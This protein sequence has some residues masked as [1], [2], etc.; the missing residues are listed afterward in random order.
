MDFFLNSQFDDILPIWL[1]SIYAIVCVNR[2]LTLNSQIDILQDLQH[3]KAWK[4][5]FQS[6]HILS[7]IS[8]FSTSLKYIELSKYV[9]GSKWR[10][11]LIWVKFNDRKYNINTYWSPILERTFTSINVFPFCFTPVSDIIFHR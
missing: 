2:S 4:P 8:E 9:K 7:Q 5:R 10:V 11:F 3:R 6:V 1:K